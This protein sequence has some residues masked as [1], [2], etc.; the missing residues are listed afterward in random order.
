M[1]IICSQDTY[2]MPTLW[3]GHG[4]IFW[5]WEPSFS[6]FPFSVWQTQNRCESWYIRVLE[7]FGE[8]SA[9]LDD[10]DVV[11]LD[12]AAMVHF[13]QPGLARSFDDYAGKV[14]IYILGQEAQRVDIIWDQYRY[15]SIKAGVR[16]QQGKGVG[17][18]RR[19][20]CNYSKLEWI[21]L[22]SR[23]QDWGLCFPC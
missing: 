21:S 11:I 10:V 2:L 5:A 19:K 3:R 13:L 23:E 1:I 22:P 15:G 9:S 8:G 7:N 16:Q 14:L 12:G 4:K 17:R 20:K 6:T 18:Q